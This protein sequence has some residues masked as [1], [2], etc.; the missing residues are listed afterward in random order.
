MKKKTLGVGIIGGG[1]NARFHIRSWVGVRNAD[2]LGVFDPDRKRAEEAAGI[3]R[4]LEVGEAKVYKSITDLVS[5]PKIDALWISA[6]NFTRIEVMEEIVQAVDTGKGEL[7][8][9]CCEK[10]LGRNVKEAKRMLELARKAELL[11]GYLENQ[12]FAPEPRSRDVLISPAPPKSTA[13]HTC[14]GSGR[15]HSK[16]GA[17][18][19]T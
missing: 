9:V 10:P 12:V 14:P 16:A 13:A 3:A 4:K 7:V 6:P 18:S 2:I 8:G 17:S 15:A 11:D 19:T 1:F 5:D